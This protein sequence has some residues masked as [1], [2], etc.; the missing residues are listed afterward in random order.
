MLKL[1]EFVWWENLVRIP[2]KYLF[3]HK[4]LL[5]LVNI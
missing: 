2:I 3:K 5:R 4:L 1:Y